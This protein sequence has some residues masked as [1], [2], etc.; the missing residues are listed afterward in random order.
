[1]NEIKQNRFDYI[2]SGAA[3]AAAATL[4][5]NTQAAG[6]LEWEKQGKEFV[7]NLQD[8]DPEVRYET[9]NSAGNLNPKVIPMI[10]ELLLSDSPGVV[11]AA[12]GA[13]ERM[14]HSVGKDLGT[15]KAEAVEAELVKLLDHDERKVKVFA[16]RTLSLIADEDS[17]AKIA[18]FAHDPAYQEEA[19]YCL[20]R[21][22]G[23]ISTKAIVK[24]AHA[25]TDLF[26]IRCIAAIA[27]RLD[28]SALDALAD[29][30]DHSNNDVK[31]AAADAIAKIGKKPES[32][33]PPA[34]DTLT[35]RQ[36]RKWLDC[37]LRWFAQKIKNEEW[38][39]AR[40]AHKD[41]AAKDIYQ[42]EE[43]YRCATIAAI[44]HMRYEP[45]VETHLR[46]FKDDPA[47]IVR[48]TAEKALNGEL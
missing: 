40:S 31:L 36:K 43:H 14:T 12:E 45:E 17:V 23:H 4:A 13:L 30:L 20:E 1:M 18:E 25:G 37:G 6:H 47:Y 5:S 39:A 9:W 7:E 29:W 22:P 28:D 3:I 21:I 2:K 10:A 46:N 8:E 44:A 48:I 35:Y 24:A 34:Y 11:K 16:L 38:D 15:E 32:G 41:I 26:T 27:N 42:N 19:I 33:M